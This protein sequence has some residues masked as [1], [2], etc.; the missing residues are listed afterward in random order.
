M[1]AMQNR[2]D[3]RDGVLDAA[4]DLRHR[5]ARAGARCRSRTGVDGVRRVRRLRALRGAA[6]RRDGRGS[7]EWSLLGRHNVMN[8]MAAIAAANHVGI[9][10]RRAALALAE[11]RGVKRRME[12]RGT[13]RGVTVYDDFAHHPDR[14]RDDA[15]GLRRGVGAA[16]IVAVLEP[17]SNTMKL[18]VHRE[19]LAPVAAGADP[20]LVP[21]VAGPRLGS[22]RGARLR[23]GARAV[24]R[25]LAW[26]NWWRR[27][28][29]DSRPPA[30]RC[31]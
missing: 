20:R 4:R 17:R 10:P 21:R 27:I 26:M 8:A 7:V 5:G 22:A 31:S 3:A 30:T 28:A 19:Q 9:E 2:C 13:V 29:A 24:L 14:H 11:F 1:A 25:G 12:V 6:A 15:R 23:S 16:R 18:G